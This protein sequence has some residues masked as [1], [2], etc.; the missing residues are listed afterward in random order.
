DKHERMRQK[1]LS[2]V[3]SLKSHIERAESKMAIH[4]DIQQ[5]DVRIEELRVSGE[6]LT[7]NLHLLRKGQTC[8][9]VPD[10]Y[11]GKEREIPLEERLTPAQNAQSYYKQYKKMRAAQRHAREQL[12]IVETQLAFLTEQL[13][14]VRKCGTAE[15]LDEIRQALIDA[16]VLRASGGQKKQAKPPATKPI[17]CLSSDGIAMLVGKNGAQNERITQG[18]QPENTWL[19]AKGIPGS[20]VII[21]HVGE[22]PEATLREAAGLA[23]WF[24]NGYRSSNVPVDYTLRRHLRKPSGA[25]AGYFTYTNEKTLF[26]T[27]AESEARRLLGE[28]MA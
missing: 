12:K 9:R 1:S 11:A 25:A 27:P 19:H 18:A 6:L 24:S 4:R 3:R 5:S 21:Q 17:S 10:Y 13:S 28:D 8:A 20:H 26:I 16:R 14:D 15:D 22:V 2:L 23:A 7:A